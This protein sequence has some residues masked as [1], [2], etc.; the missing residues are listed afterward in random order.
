MK[1][2][3]GARALVNSSN[4]NKIL[5]PT[6]SKRTKNTANILQIAREFAILGGGCDPGGEVLK[7]HKK[8]IMNIS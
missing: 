1:N 8:V 5:L 6:K 4:I 3:T 2:H 7:R